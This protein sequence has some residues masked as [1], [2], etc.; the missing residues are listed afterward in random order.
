LIWI[1][2]THTLP[3][4]P[5][6]CHTFAVPIPQVVR[7]LTFSWIWIHTVGLVRIP[8]LPC[9]FGWI[10]LDLFGCTH[11]WIWL[12]HILVGWITLFGLLPADL[13]FPHLWIADT[14]TLP[15]QVTLPRLRVTCPLDRLRLRVPRVGLP[16]PL[17]L[18]CH[19]PH[20]FADLP[21]TLCPGSRLVTFVPW[22]V[23]LLF[24]CTLLL[25]LDLELPSLA[26]WNSHPCQLPGYTFGLDYTHRVPHTRPS[27]GFP[28]RFFGLRLY[29]YTGFYLYTVLPHHPLPHTLVVAL[30]THAHLHTH[31]FGWLVVRVVVTTRV[32]LLPVGWFTHLW[33]LPHTP[34]WVTQ[35]PVT[36]GF[37]LLLFVDCVGFGFGWVTFDSRF[38]FYIA[39]RC[40]LGWVPTLPVGCHRLQDS[41]YTLDYPTP[42]HTR[43]PRTGCYH[44]YVW[45]LLPDVG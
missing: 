29:T 20:P 41:R 44:G 31:T 30:P 27:L 15:L 11:G 24:R 22:N 39:S 13:Q 37:P 7:I 16:L 33:T 12:T 40:T 1:A 43:C 8:T 6:G 28:L 21:V 42:L 45:L 18:R 34:L 9:S 19:T 17:P 10:A 14:H 38:G 32:G 26:R 4:L 2:A 3:I 23:T 5:L 35:P 36:F 25:R